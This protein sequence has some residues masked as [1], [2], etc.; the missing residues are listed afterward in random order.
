MTRERAFSVVAPQLWDS[1]SRA[2]SP[3]PSLRTFR[4]CVK[5]ELGR[6]SYTITP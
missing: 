5:T 3:A 1:L 4:R 2:A 6:R